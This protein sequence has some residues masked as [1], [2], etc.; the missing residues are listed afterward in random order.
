MKR[1]VPPRQPWAPI[2]PKKEY[3]QNADLFDFAKSLPELSSMQDLID[4]FNEFYNT[5]YTTKDFTLF[6][7]SISYEGDFVAVNPISVGSQPNLNYK[8]EYRLYQKDL[9]KYNKDLEKYNQDI[10]I[11]NE[12]IRKEAEQ[13]ANSDIKELE[14]QIKSL[15]EK[16]LQIK[17]SL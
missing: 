15:N 10:K 16:I 11:Y 2:E 9:K 6:V 8:E 4:K 14:K 7:E 3:E 1:I 13:L 17:E 5:S 12:H